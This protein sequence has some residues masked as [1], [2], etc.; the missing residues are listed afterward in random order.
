MVP[1]LDEAEAD[2]GGSPKDG[3]SREEDPRSDL[4]Q[5]DGRW[6]L[7]QDVGDEEDEN[8]DRVAFS[9][10][11]E[12]DTHTGDDGDTLL[13]ALVDA[14]AGV[15]VRQTTYCVGSVHERDTVHSSEGQD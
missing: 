11:F 12:V 6:W 15:R 2:H 8:D 5:D 7:Q 1:F 3:D 13:R 14:L 4:S 9:D 10:E